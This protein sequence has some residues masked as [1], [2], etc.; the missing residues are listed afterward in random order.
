MGISS[1]FNRHPDDACGADSCN[2]R[3]CR[4]AGS[5]WRSRRGACE[6]VPVYNLLYIVSVWI[7]GWRFLGGNL[8]SHLCPPDRRYA[9]ACCM[10]ISRS[11]CKWFDRIPAYGAVWKRFDFCGE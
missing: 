3:S 6:R 11:T 5:A 10:G 7:F 9:D 8:R 2:N 4:D 1:F